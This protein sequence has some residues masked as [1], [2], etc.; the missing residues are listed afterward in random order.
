VVVADTAMITYGQTIDAQFV[1]RHGI[2]PR[3]FVR[4]CL[5]PSLFA[6]QRISCLYKD[7]LVETHEFPAWKTRLRALRLVFAMGDAEELARMQVK[8][9]R[10]VLGPTQLKTIANGLLETDCCWLELS[11]LARRCLIPAL[12]A[13]CTVLLFYQGRSVDSLRDKDW[14]TQFE[15]TKMLLRLHRAFADERDNILFASYRDVALLISE[16]QKKNRTIQVFGQ[17]KFIRLR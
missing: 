13:T 9:P 7:T 1:Q 11:V 17:S 5:R 4:D 8:L 6:M 2:T 16:R 3:A 10:G 12:E 15:A 14:N